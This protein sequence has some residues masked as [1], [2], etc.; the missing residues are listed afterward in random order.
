M[1]NY[2]DSHPKPVISAWR[3]NGDSHHNL[4]ILSYEN[5]GFMA[6]AAIQYFGRPKPVFM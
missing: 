6:S 5:K 3:K 4:E 1:C 2:G